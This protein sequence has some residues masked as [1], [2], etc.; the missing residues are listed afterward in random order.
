MPINKDHSFEFDKRS[1]K[2][3]IDNLVSNALKF[4]KNGTVE[5]T[6]NEISRQ[7]SPYLEIT[8]KDSGIGIELD[9]IDLYLSPFTQSD[10]SMTR[11]YGG[12]GIGLAAVKTCIEKYEG[13]INFENNQEAGTIVTV[14]LPLENTSETNTSRFKYTNAA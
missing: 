14:L 5:L 4:T 8:V 7:D 3:I 9:K 10:M 13:T 6:I 12:L 2:L 11:S 1:L